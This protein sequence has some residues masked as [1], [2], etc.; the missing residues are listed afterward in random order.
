MGA[1]QHTNLGE[2]MKLTNNL[3]NRILD[4]QQKLTERLQQL[5]WLE[6]LWDERVTRLLADHPAHA[7]DCAF[8]RD[9]ARDQAR[10]VAAE[11]Y[12]CENLLAQLPA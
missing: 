4:D 5:T 3:K 2:P 7:G 10:S 8:H 6:R 11:L 9:A 12:A 1:T